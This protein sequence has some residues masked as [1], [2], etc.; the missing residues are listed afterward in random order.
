LI[1]YYNVKHGGI[2]RKSGFYSGIL[3]EFF[4]QYCSHD[5]LN[6][7][8]KKVW[9]IICSADFSDPKV[10]SYAIKTANFGVILLELLVVDP[11]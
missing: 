4:E 11:E 3:F 5:I 9:K 10:K 8:Q 1:F 7:S 6:K 2:Y